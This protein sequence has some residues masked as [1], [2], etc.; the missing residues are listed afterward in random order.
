LIFCILKM[1][2]KISRIWVN[3][4][5]SMSVSRGN[6]LK[7][8]PPARRSTCVGPRPGIPLTVVK[9]LEPCLLRGSNSRPARTFGSTGRG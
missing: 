5:A 2:C 7:K 6:D 3:C 9:V 4:T 8:C 1:A